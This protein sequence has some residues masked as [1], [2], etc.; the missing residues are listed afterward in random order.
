MRCC[1]KKEMCSS[2]QWKGLR[3]LFTFRA[4]WKPLGRATPSLSCSLGG[5][6]GT[7]EVSGSQAKDIHSGLVGLCVL[8][9]VLRGILPEWQVTMGHCF[10]QTK[11]QNLEQYDAVFVKNKTKPQLAGW[12][13]GSLSKSLHPQGNENRPRKSQKA[14][15]VPPDTLGTTQL[16]L[17]GRAIDGL[18]VLFDSGCSVGDGTQGLTHG[19]HTPTAYTLNPASYIL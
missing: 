5:Q 17:H 16:K 18:Q 10:V 8:R 15:C 4:S 14:V 12:L 13:A 2:C 19:K 7:E 3:L 6:V 11:W 9:C 1:I